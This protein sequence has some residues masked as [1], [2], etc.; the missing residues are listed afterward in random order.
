MQVLI[1]DDSPV[2]R[3]VLGAKLVQWGYETI[4]V[5]NGDAAWEVLASPNSPRLA[6]IDWRMPGIDGTEICRRLRVRESLRYTFVLLMTSCTLPNSVVEG[7]KA[8]ADDF[9]RK[10]FDPAELEQRLRTGRRIVELQ[11]RLLAAQE[12]LRMQATHDSLTGLWNR[13]EIL[14]TF[15]REWDRMRRQRSAIGA[16]MIDVDFFK[17]VN[18]EHGHQAGDDVLREMGRQLPQS[19]RS[20]DQVGRVGGE[21]FLVV[22]PN[23]TIRNVLA[24]GERARYR[25][26]QHPIVIGDRSIHVT[27]SVGAASSS[28]MIDSPKELIQRADQAL[29]AAKRGG[30]NRVASSADVVAINDDSIQPP[31]VASVSF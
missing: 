11:D 25:I 26:E 16:M 14:R 1:A 31:H 20:Y 22:L 6:I 3:R 5:D 13:A 19:V 9:V 17:Q 23:A 10:P 28:E 27:V 8:G 2:S 12:S 21:E 29:Y 15:D 24:I 18:D 7:L 30:R 4:V